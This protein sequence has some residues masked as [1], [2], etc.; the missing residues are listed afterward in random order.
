MKTQCEEIEKLLFLKAEELSAIEKDKLQDHL[1]KC[2]ECRAEYERNMQLLENIRFRSPS[3]N[4]GF[5][6]SRIIQN[7][8]KHQDSNLNRK[9][10]L[11]RRQFLKALAVASVF[12]F[13]IFSVEQA[14]TVK[15]ITRLEKKLAET[16]GKTI[17]QKGQLL[18]L[19]HF[20]TM[21][22][23]K[24]IVNPGFTGQAYFNSFFP[25]PVPGSLSLLNNRGQKLLQE[26]L[27][28]Q[29]LGSVIFSGKFYGNS[30]LLNPT[31]EKNR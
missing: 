23:L 16:N 15:K 19:N 5:M 25:K 29:P 13:I 28:A 21:D 14:N 4:S 1:D 24:Q 22:D 10:I 7:L 2:Q 6:E 9:P 27:E 26:L 3:F 31:F 11:V 30:E 17:H 18:V 12:F 8:E 20:Y